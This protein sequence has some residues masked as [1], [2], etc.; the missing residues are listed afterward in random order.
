MRRILPSLF[1]SAATFFASQGQA[2]ELHSMMSFDQV[3]QLSTEAEEY[4]QKASYAD[5]HVNYDEAVRLLAKAAEIDTKNGDLQ[6]LTASRARNRAEIYYSENTYTP[7]PANVDYYTPPWQTAEQY[8][9]IAEACLNRL[10]ANADVPAEQRTRLK[11]AQATLEARRS[12]IIERDKARIKSAE[13]IYEYYRDTRYQALLRNLPD[14]AQVG[15]DEVS[16]RIAKAMGL[17][18]IKV[19]TA[20]GQDL[21]PPVDDKDKNKADPFASLPGE[22]IQPFLPPPPPPPGANG[23]GETAS[24]GAIDPFAAGPAPGFEGGNPPPADPG[25][26]GK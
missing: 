19:T 4:Y 21:T 13:P 7:A 26:A 25:F 24:P 12:A 18:G 17:A 16:Q 8:F 20:K 11:S 10:S 9:N 3:K 15:D 1:A 14:D 22:Y 5:D 2:Q 6:F 23:Y